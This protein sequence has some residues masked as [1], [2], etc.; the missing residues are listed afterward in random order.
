M[1]IHS[2]HSPVTTCHVKR[3]ANSVIIQILFNVAKLIFFVERAAHY[4]C[5]SII[6][7]FSTHCREQYVSYRSIARVNYRVTNVGN[8]KCVNPHQCVRLLNRLRQYFI[9]FFTVLWFKRNRIKD[10]WI[11]TL[12]AD[13]TMKL[14]L[15]DPTRKLLLAD[16]TTKHI[17]VCS[18]NKT[19]LLFTGILTTLSYRF[20][21][22]ASSMF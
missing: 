21:R 4:L 16:T 2:R 20:V 1:F 7:Y 3:P 10:T 12:L 5:I 18:N 17:V 9:M 15:A 13:P 19:T 11:K 14:L 8:E 22:K 6:V